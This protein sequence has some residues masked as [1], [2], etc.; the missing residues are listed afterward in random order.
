[1]SW[2]IKPESLDDSEVIYNKATCFMACHPYFI[3]VAKCFKDL[4]CMSDIFPDLT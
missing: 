2:I 1:M 3:C 4:P